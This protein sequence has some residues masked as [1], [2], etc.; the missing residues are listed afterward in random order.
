[1]PFPGLIFRSFDSF[2]WAW[3]WTP[4]ADAHHLFSPCVDLRALAIIE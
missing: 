2:Q 1:M 4:I 3:W